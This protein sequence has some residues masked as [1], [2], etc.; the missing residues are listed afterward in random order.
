M[1]QS[2][3]RYPAHRTLRLQQH[4]GSGVVLHKQ[5]HQADPALDNPPT[6]LDAPHGVPHPDPSTVYQNYCQI[7]FLPAREPH[8]TF[9]ARSTRMGHG[10]APRSG[11]TPGFVK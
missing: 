11:Y 7:R 6:R 8:F 9:H 5:A 4:R 3:R 10:V 2:T 1:H